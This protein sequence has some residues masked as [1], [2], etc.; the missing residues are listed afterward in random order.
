[1]VVDQDQGAGI[2]HQRLLDDLTRV[3]RNVVD[4]ADRHERVRDDAV[5]AVKIEDMEPLDGTSDGQSTIVH[6]RLPAADDRVLTEVAAED[7]T[8]LEDDGFFL[9][10][11]GVGSH[12]MP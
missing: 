7:V 5:L 8:G 4:R 10:G 12:E 6:Q 11:H 2:Q 9:G 1:M 3:D